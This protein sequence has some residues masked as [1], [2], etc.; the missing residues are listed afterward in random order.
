MIENY[1][2]INTAR[3]L[4][5]RNLDI[6]SEAVYDRGGKNIYYHKDVYAGQQNFFKHF[7][8]AYN[9][10]ECNRALPP[11]IKIGADVFLLFVEFS[12]DGKTVTAGYKRFGLKPKLLIDFK[13]KTET[14]AKG[15]L[16]HWC[17]CKGYL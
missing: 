17:S 10:E 15:K 6:P 3:L 8:R 7:T 2:S 1:I 9:N 16:L 11:K 13:S 14:D 12:E 4:K 5:A